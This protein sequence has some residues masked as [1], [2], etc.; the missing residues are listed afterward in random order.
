MAAMT[1][2]VLDRVLS[3]SAVADLGARSSHSPLFPA[4][5]V[6]DVR[7]GSVEEL[8]RAAVGWDVRYVQLDSGRC[9]NRHVSLHTGRMQLRFE[10]WSLGT[11]KIG[12]P[13]A[14]AM[15]FLVP[16]GGESRC[17]IQG[18]PV[19]AG[20]VVTLSDRDEFDY[21][22]TGTSWL[23]SVSIERALLE[24]HVRTLFGR[25]LGEL[26]L[27]GRL[28]GFR[29]DHVGLRRLCRALA[30]R[31]AVRP[32]FLR[33][34]AAARTVEKRVVQMLFA[35]FEAPRDM[36]A[37]SRGRALALRAEAWL[38]QNLADPPT[39][40]ALCAALN[41]SER[42]L[43]EAFRAHLGAT[44]KSYL[45]T[46][47][48][49][50]A[51][52]DLLRARPRTR[53]TDVALDWGFFHFGWFSQDYRRLFAETPSQT[54]QRARVDRGRGSADGKG[55]PSGLRRVGLAG[56]RDAAFALGA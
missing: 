8:E 27:L 23:V 7:V 11:M 32:G 29:T 18:R 21:R 17:R 33:G 49:N 56:G 54:L 41:A 28:R 16:G 50:A 20:E 46:L 39:I 10:S 4:G 35:R 40:A 14:G 30:A 24:A 13:P 1:A 6:M 42:T 22:S 51:H 25:H 19:G 47:R 34:R 38:R 44:P 2:A 53:V 43:H 55:A 31:A 37:P 48:L 9:L 15:T 36:D 5:H 26:R 3:S 45:K 12:R 52:H